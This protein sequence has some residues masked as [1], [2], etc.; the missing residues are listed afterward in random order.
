MDDLDRPGLPKPLVLDRD[1]ECTALLNDM[2]AAGVRLLLMPINIDADGECRI[3]ACE[4]RLR[5]RVRRTRKFDDHLSSLADRMK[6]LVHAA[7]DQVLES[8]G[9]EAREVVGNVRCICCP[10]DC[11]ISIEFLYSTQLL[12]GLRERTDLLTLRMSPL[13]DSR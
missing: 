6:E 5:T 1:P 11:E 2:A 3:L 4:W 8:C 13:N 9:H 12:L 10:S 7:L